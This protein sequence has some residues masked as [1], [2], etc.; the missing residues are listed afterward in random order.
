MQLAQFQQIQKL[1]KAALS[2]FEHFTVIKCLSNPCFFLFFF[3]PRH[4]D[5]LTGVYISNI[6]IIL[7]IPET[8]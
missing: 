3:I 8:N 5:L 7:E 6:G 4:L 2:L 1:R